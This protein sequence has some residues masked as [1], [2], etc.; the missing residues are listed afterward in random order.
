MDTLERQKDRIE[1][2]TLR[3]RSYEHAFKLAYR[4]TGNQSDAEDL[5]Q[6]AFVRAWEAFDRYDR[7]RSFEVWL[8]QV[9][10]NLAIDRWR[11]SGH[12]MPSLDQLL[13]LNG[14]NVTLGAVVPY[15]GPSPEQQC[16][17][18][19]Q[20][21]KVQEALR[22]LPDNYRTVVVLTDIEEWSYVEVAAKM[23]CPVGTV[24]SRLHRGRQLLRQLLQKMQTENGI[25]SGRQSKRAS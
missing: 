23:G 9:L 17:L 18:R 13:S 14:S 8:M 10:S 1:F 22:Q 19:D 11:R 12:R 21:D 5:T 2:D 6:D 25:P 24:R 4:F 7:R 16:I 15:Q 20:A 3:S